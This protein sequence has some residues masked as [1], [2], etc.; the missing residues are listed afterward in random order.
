MVLTQE[1]KDDIYITVSIELVRMFDI[2]NNVYSRPEHKEK[3]QL[4]ND[5]ETSLRKDWE[6]FKL[7]A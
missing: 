7:P 3:A 1:E 5:L 2:L 4:I 6:I